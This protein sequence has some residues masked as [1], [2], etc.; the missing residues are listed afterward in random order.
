MCGGTNISLSSLVCP[1]QQKYVLQGLFSYKG[2]VLGVFLP[3]R[4]LRSF[5]FFP[6]SLCQT[7][8]IL[9]V[10]ALAF[11]GASIK[12]GKKSGSQWGE[13][14][15]V[16]GSNICCSRPSQKAAGI[17]PESPLIY[18]ND[19]QI[20]RQAER[21]TIC[22]S[23]GEEGKDKNNFCPTVCQFLLLSVCMCQWWWRGEQSGNHG[24]SKLPD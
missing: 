14:H 16:P 20:E 10:G 7:T 8:A 24:N 18:C 13:I 11:Q 4:G 15:F 19:R 17:K 2:F 1:D 9:M 22:R 12:E 21:V 3:S 23:E 5:L 6:P